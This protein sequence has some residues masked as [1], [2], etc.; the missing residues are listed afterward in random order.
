MECTF[1]I[2]PIYGS[3]TLAGYWEAAGEEARP[4]SPGPP[5]APHL[6]GN[7][8]MEEALT[9]T[10]WKELLLRGANFP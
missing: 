2:Q 7:P 3:Q 8:D 5:E 9:S 1:F 4:S 10:V 6:L